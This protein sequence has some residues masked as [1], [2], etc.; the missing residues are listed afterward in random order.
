MGAS[1]VNY[2]EVAESYD[3]RTKDGY[4]SGVVEALEGLARRVNVRRV[5]DLGCGTGRSLV[6]PA[7]L[8][9]APGC[10]GL[11][12]SA[13]M[14]A[15]ARVFNPNYRLVR[16]SAPQP[17][18]APLS[19]DM[20]FCVHAFHHFPDKDRVVQAAYELLRP[21]GAF[22]IVNFDPRES[23]DGWFAYRYFEGTCET[24]LA[25]FPALEDLERMLREAGFEDIDSP[26]VERVAD[27]STGA[28]VFESYFLQKDACSQFILLSDAAYEAGLAQMRKAIAEAEAKGEEV[29]FRTEI[30]SRM[31]HGVK[32]KEEK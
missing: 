18:F 23:R 1:R 22:A 27:N 20:V 6:G 21:G 4:L 12:L 5:L 13:G 9:P 10:F 7:R 11:D 15:Q 24:D 8:D 14:L 3:R 31:F 17:P 16:A 29:E 30:K 32:P 28:S 19:F 25:R 26:V 2:D